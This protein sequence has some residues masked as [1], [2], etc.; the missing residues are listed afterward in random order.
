[1]SHF[2]SFQTGK[3][4]RPTKRKSDLFAPD[5]GS[6][7]SAPASKVKADATE[8][9][10]KLSSASLASHSSSSSSSS[11]SFSSSTAFPFSSKPSPRSSSSFVLN[12]TPAAR[13]SST[14]LASIA[15]QGVN[16]VPVAPQIL[17]T[18][19]QSERAKSLQSMFGVCLF[20]FVRKCCLTVC[21][22][23]FSV[24]SGGVSCCRVSNER[25]GLSFTFAFLFSCCSC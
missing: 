17:R 2:L 8:N 19:Q 24:H 5:F 11:S 18:A 4:A 12:L 16:F 22:L 25:I 3:F 6:T 7:L 15:S 13:S 23:L 9:K 20:S 14:P 10:S 21:S 1:M